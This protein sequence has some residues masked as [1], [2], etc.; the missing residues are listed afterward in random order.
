MGNIRSGLGVCACREMVEH[1]WVILKFLIID[2]ILGYLYVFQ[3]SVS[4][5]CVCLCVYFYF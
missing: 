5:L 2:V 1:E 3:K 4:A